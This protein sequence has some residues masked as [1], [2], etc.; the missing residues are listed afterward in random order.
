MPCCFLEIHIFSRG[1]FY[2]GLYT[3]S[4]KLVLWCA[5][6]IEYRNEMYTVYKQTSWHKMKKLQLC[7]FVFQNSHFVRGL[8]LRRTLQTVDENINDYTQVGLIVHTLQL[9]RGILQLRASSAKFY[10]KRKYTLCSRPIYMYIL[11]MMRPSPV[12]G[13][14]YLQHCVCLAG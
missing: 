10:E 8:F 7:L 5:L 1:C 9:L 6:W 14:L 13:R 4:L 12:E 11:F 2:D 3:L